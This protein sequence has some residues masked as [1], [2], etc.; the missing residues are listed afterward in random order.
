VSNELED[1][2]QGDTTTI[3]IEAT[4]GARAFDLQGYNVYF[5]VGSKMRIKGDVI[6]PQKGRAEFHL[7]GDN[8][9]I[10]QGVYQYTIRAIKGDEKRVLAQ[11]NLLIRGV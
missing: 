5:I 10:P 6:Q 7:S 11:D 4:E 8:T 9:N 2:W 3:E 1:I